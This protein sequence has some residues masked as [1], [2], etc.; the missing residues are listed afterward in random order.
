MFFVKFQ[1]YSTKGGSG[2]VVDVGLTVLV[3]VVVFTADVERRV[4][5]E[6][7]C[8]RLCDGTVDGSLVCDVGPC[9]DCVA[10]VSDVC[11]FTVVVV[12]GA[13]VAFVV[14]TFVIDVCF[15]VVEVDIGVVRARKI[16]TQ[17]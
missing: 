13:A 14:E 17:L 16:Y 7:E 11:I 3:S 6:E 2:V 12:L 10:F 1:R 8:S 15:G 9:V 5:A 4:L